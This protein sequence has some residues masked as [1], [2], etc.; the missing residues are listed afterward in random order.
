ML[1][2]SLREMKWDQCVE[3]ELATIVPGDSLVTRVSSA[4][5]CCAQYIRQK[6][7]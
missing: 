6:R 3:K 5:R 1:T 4:V 7:L 2:M